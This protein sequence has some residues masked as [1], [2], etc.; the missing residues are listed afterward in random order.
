MTASLLTACA[1]Q[2]EKGVPSSYAIRAPFDD[3]AAS[4]Q[5]EN[6]GGRV[7]GS[8]YVTRVSTASSSA[9]P[10][11][12]ITCAGMPVVLLPVTD[13]ANERIQVLYG[14]QPQNMEVLSRSGQLAAKS[15]VLFT[16]DVPGY[17]QFTRSTVCDSR[18]QFLMGNVKDGDYYL[19]S[20]VSWSNVPFDGQ[21]MLTRIQVSNGQVPAV[22]LS[23]IERSP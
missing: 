2:P 16:P 10:G 20:L 23:S 9:N 22:I 4:S 17:Q 1:S 6:G 21:L 12:V 7:N 5:V 11:S 15:K 19:F 3:M 13:Y 18:G 14:R 8:A